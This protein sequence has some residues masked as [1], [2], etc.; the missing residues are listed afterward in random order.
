MPGYAPGATVASSRLL[1]AIGRPSLRHRLPGLAQ[2]LAVLVLAAMAAVGL[3]LPAA[4]APIEIYEHFT[5]IDGRGGAAQPDAAMA[6]SAGR[7]IWVGQ[8]AAVPD[9]AGSTIV[10]LSGKF[11]IPGLIDAHVHLG[12]TIGLD[13]DEKFYTREN[14][15]RDLA[16]YASF[17]VTTVASM[18]TDKDIVFQI[19]REQH[20]SAPRVARLFTA[21]QGLVFKGGYGGV[22]GVNHPVDTPEAAIAEVDAQA[23]KSADYIKLWLDDDFGRLP[24]MPAAISQAI[25]TE[26]H[27]RGLHAY[28]HIFYLE[29]AKRLVGQGIDGFVH[30]VRD[31]PIDAELIAAMRLHGVV[32]ESGTLSREDSLVQFGRDAPEFRDPF[33]KQAMSPETLSRLKSLQRRETIRVSPTYPK[34]EQSDVQAMANMK[35]LAAAGIPFGMGTDS[36]PPGRF[37]GYFA[38]W[39]LARLVQAGLSPAQALYLATGASARILGAGEIGTL[40]QSKWADFVVLT[41]DPLANILNTRKIAA[42]YIAGR[43]VPSIRP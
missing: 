27:R 7:I 33:F 17:G 2:R 14:V 18:G 3:P 24:K 37:G 35:A 40:E 42:V 4:A 22:P 43:Q 13:Q 32:Q 41:A 39:E 8:A 36:G 38:H 30:T 9:W 11:V 10:D 25:I 26:A 1:E 23:D 31:K 21:G 19:R 16:L 6:V 20:E 15:E 5:M 28:A 12:N 34:L 29:D